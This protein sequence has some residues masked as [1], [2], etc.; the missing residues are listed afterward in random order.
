MKIITQVMCHADKTWQLMKFNWKNETN[1]L[2]VD[3]INY[4]PYDIDEYVL[5]EGTTWM[6]IYFV[7]EN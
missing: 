2:V 5:M 7:N 6:K 1:H 4:E 3:E